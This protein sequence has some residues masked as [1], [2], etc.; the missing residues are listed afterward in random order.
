M[1]NVLFMLRRIELPTVL[2]KRLVWSTA[3][4]AL[5]DNFSAFIM[6]MTFLRAPAANLRLNALESLITGHFLTIIALPGSFTTFEPL[7]VAGFPTVVKKP[8]FRSRWASDAVLRYTTI[9]PYTL[10]TS[11]LLN[12][13]TF[14]IW[15]FFSQPSTSATPVM[16]LPVSS[17]IA[18]RLTLSTLTGYRSSRRT[19]AP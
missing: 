9:E 1:R 6:S 18:V 17:R 15:V 11:C 5:D 13:L 7:G 19:L 4:D 10:G 16:T 8:S 3:R 14:A 2:T 12:Q